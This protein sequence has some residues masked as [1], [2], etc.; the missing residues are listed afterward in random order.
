[1]LEKIKKFMGIAEGIDVYDDEI[2]FWIDAAVKTMTETAGIPKTLFREDEE[3]E[4]AVVAV[5]WYVRANFGNDRTD[6]NRCYT[7]FKHKVRELQCE[8]G[9]AWDAESEGD[10]DVDA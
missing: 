10:P 1:M 2:I 5:L 9:G 3:D 8:D 4:R 6:T 7:Q